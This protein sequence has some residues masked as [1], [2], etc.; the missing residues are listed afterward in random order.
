MTGR[1]DKMT[2]DQFDEIL[3]DKC[4][5]LGGSHVLHIPGVYEI[6]AEYY[7]N[8]VLTAWEGS[9]EDP[10]PDPDPCAERE[11]MDLRDPCKH[12]L[13]GACRLCTQE[14]GEELRRRWE[15]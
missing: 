12:G 1:Y 4:Q 9:Q 6:V 15:P 8:D 10:E 13:R 7:N 2:Q 14:A 5:A 11:D 3:D